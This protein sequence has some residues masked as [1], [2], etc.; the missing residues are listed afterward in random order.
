MDKTILDLRA[1]NLVS[2]DEWEFGATVP[3]TYIVYRSKN[4]IRKRRP[5]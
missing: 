1:E 2:T 4:P 3:R 5:G